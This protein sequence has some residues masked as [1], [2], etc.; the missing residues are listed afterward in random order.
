MQ[1]LQPR[2]RRVEY[3]LKS[4]SKQRL[5]QFRVVMVSAAAVFFMLSAG[6]SKPPD[7]AAEAEKER[8]AGQAETAKAPPAVEPAK[9]QPKEIAKAT[10]PAEPPKEEKKEPIRSKLLSPAALNERAPATFKVRM[11]TSRGDIV[12]QVTRA[13]APRGADRFYNLVK[14]GFYDEARF[15]RVV[16]NFVVQFG[17]PADPNVGRAWTNATFR[18]DP[19]KQSNKR[20]YV[21]FATAGRDTRTTQLFINLKDNAFLDSQGFSPFGEVVE[22]M[23]LVESIYSG[24]GETPDQGAIT[25][26]GNAYLR[27]NFPNLDYI[28]AATIE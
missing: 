3:I 4:M 24:Y 14:N 1:P 21:V 18:D 25:N 19:V 26:Q 22:G 17:L 28:K 2:G 6:C 9:E 5:N 7:R 8:A 11:A 23:E 27:R 13:W 10:P 20:G 12:V 16:P 15:F